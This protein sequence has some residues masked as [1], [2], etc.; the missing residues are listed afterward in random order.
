MVPIWMKWVAESWIGKFFFFWSDQVSLIES[1]SQLH[2]R[3][4]QKD[5]FKQMQLKKL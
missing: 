2:H 3:E 4:T 1:Q 5:E